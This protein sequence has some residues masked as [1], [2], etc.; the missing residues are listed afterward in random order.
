MGADAPHHGRVVPGE[1]AC[2]VS[3]G[4]A[5]SEEGEVGTAGRGRVRCTKTDAQVC[6][7]TQMPTAAPSGGQPSKGMRQMP[8]TSS[9]AK[10]G[11]AVRGSERCHTPSAAAQA[12]ANQQRPAKPC[13]PARRCASP[14]FHVQLATACH[15]LIFTSNV[16]L[17]TG[18]SWRAQLQ[19]GR[20]QSTERR[21][22]RLPP[23]ADCAL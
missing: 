2:S 12:A 11:W 14:A 7:H 3:V 5:E 4:K 22:C 1:L 19:Q 9:P 8:H 16:M 18:P 17:P 10:P 20:R 15:F 13:P 21:R 6:R 23:P